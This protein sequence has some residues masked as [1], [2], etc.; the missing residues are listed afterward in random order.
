MN[1]AMEPYLLH[2]NSTKNYAS[3]MILLNPLEKNKMPLKKRGNGMK[4]SEDLI[5][6]V[7][8]T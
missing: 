7:K 4:M 1:S 6:V 3:D 8:L 5:S 2:T